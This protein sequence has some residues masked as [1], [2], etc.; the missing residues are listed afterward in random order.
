MYTS[1]VDEDDIMAV[2]GQDGN[3]YVVLEVIQLQVSGGTQNWVNALFPI[4]LVLLIG[5]YGH[6]GLTVQK[7]HDICMKDWW[8]LF[9]VCNKNVHST[10]LVLQDGEGHVMMSDGIPVADTSLDGTGV[11]GVLAASPLM[12]PETITPDAITAEGIG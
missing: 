5:F 3:Q 4:Q 7:W 8:W 12:V 2:D 11:G 1:E 6:F 9:G 10:F